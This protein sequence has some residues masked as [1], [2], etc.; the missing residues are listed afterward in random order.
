MEFSYHSDIC[1]PDRLVD[2]FNIFSINQVIGYS[3]TGSASWT[4]STESGVELPNIIATEHPAD[5]RDL[6]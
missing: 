6:V 1:S 3:V 2:N 5:V 4:S